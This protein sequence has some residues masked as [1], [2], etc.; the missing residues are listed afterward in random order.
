MSIAE[1]DDGYSGLCGSFARASERLIATGN[2]PDRIG[3]PGDQHL[4]PQLNRS[5]IRRARADWPHWK[6]QRSLSGSGDVTT[7][8]SNKLISGLPSS[9]RD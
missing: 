1:L 7:P 5:C 3:F 9:P 4:N 6:N 8:P 2:N